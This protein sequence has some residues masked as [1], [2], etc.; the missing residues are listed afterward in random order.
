MEQDPPLSVYI[1]IYTTWQKYL[2]YG[3]IS[4]SHP[5]RVIF[6]ETS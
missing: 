5:K 4:I 2:A 1:Y 3:K 6:D